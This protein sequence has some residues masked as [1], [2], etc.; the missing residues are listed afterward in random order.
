MLATLQAPRQERTMSAWN[1]PFYEEHASPSSNSGLLSP[2]ARF[3][4]FR[5]MDAH[6][7]DAAVVAKK[8]FL[9]LRGCRV[10]STL[11]PTCQVHKQKKNANIGGVV[12]VVVVIHVD[13][14]S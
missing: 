11:V 14:R 13:H 9:H 8:M 6:L 7:H 2:R 5:V 10:F 4:F 12:Q 1:I 3:V